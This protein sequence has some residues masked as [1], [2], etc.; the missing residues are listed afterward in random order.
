MSEISRE[1]HKKNPTKK[2][3]HTTLTH[4]LLIFL[5]YRKDGVL[6]QDIITALGTSKKVCDE[7]IS[8]LKISKF[9]EEKT[10]PRR[11]YKIKKVGEKYTKDFIEKVEKND[12]L[13]LMLR[14]TIEDIDKLRTL[15]Y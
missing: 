1:T 4:L 12:D 15:R 14:I 7:L 11:Y 2:R 6:Q 9:V 5:F 10:K 3:D 13:A 8:D